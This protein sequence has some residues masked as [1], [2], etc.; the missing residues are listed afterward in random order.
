MESYTAVNPNKPLLQ[1]YV[2]YFA[3]VFQFELGKSVWY[4]EPVASVIGK[5][6]PWTILLVGTSMLL[7]YLIGIVL[8]AAFAYIEGSS[9][10]LGG[11]VF[12]TVLSAT[13]N[14]VMAIVLIYFMGY[15][16]GLFPTSGR[17]SQDIAP[18]LR[19][20]YLLSALHHAALPIAALVITGFGNRAMSM[21]GNSIQE[22]GKDYLRVARL[23][24]LSSRRIAMRYV[25]RNAILPMYTGFMVSIGFMF[26][27]S[28]IVEEIFTYRGIGFLLYKAADTRDDP[29]LMGCFIVITFAVVTGIYVADMTYGL[30]DPRADGGSN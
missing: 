7:I 22:L 29:L 23:R 17:V 16:T 5:A 27:A 8:G 9:L 10:D 18:G 11:S 13:P 12:S 21:R 30:I 2:D 14:Y 1:Q 20:P 25:A 26:G 6:L 19:I 24:G 3:N 28:V 4:G 15:S